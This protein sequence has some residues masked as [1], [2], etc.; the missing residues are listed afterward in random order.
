MFFE[1]YM[2]LKEKIK[3]LKRK[4]GSRADFGPLRQAGPLRSLDCRLVMVKSKGF[5]AKFSVRG[6]WTAG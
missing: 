2:V 3:P 5:F 1:R 6:V 4:R